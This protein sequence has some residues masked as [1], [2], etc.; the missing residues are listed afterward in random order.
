M[1]SQLAE[2]LAES[3]LCRPGTG[4]NVD[5][6]TAPPSTPRQLY[7][8][9]IEDQIEEYKAALTR[10]ELMDLADQAV[11]ELFD[12]PD[13]QYP[14]TEILLRDAVDALLFERLRLPDY[15]QWLRTCHSDTGAR[16]RKGTTAPRRLG[17]RNT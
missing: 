17:K 9:W 11:K 7:Q 15:R 8:A 14:L 12:S 10:D 13:G 4:P 3:H 1:V 6:M 5:R 16:P 2:A